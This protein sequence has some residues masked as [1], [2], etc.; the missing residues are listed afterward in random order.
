MVGTVD[1]AVRQRMGLLTG[2]AITHDGCVGHVVIGLGLHQQHI[3]GKLRTGMQRPVAL[4]AHQGAAI[5][6]QIEFVQIA[7]GRVP[8]IVA[9]QRRH[10]QRQP[11]HGA[12]RRQDRSQVTAI[13]GA[14]HGN[15]RG[16]E[17][18]VREQAI[19][20]R[21]QVA[22]V[23]FTGHPGQRNAGAA[24][25]PAQVE[26]Q[27]HTT[28]AGDAFRPFQVALLTTAPTVHE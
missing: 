14:H 28:Q 20:G 21:Q 26:G 18:R 23:V 19:V 17:R 13:A 2:R 8:L 16:I 11:A 4:G 25:M 27:A 15:R 10:P 7:L 5:I 6:A 22:Q 12:Q 3:P 1:D 9:V 24:G